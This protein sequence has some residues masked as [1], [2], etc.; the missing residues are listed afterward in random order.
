MPLR[1][2]QHQHFNIEHQHNTKTKKPPTSSQH[3]SFTIISPTVPRPRRRGPRRGARALRP[4]SPTLVLLRSINITVLLTRMAS[5]RACAELARGNGQ[6]DNQ[7]VVNCERIS[8]QLC[9]TT[10]MVKWQLPYSWL[11]QATLQCNSP[12][13]SLVALSLRPLPPRKPWSTQLEP[14]R[15]HRPALFR[16]GSH[17][18]CCGDIGTRPGPIGT[19]GCKPRAGRRHGYDEHCS[20]WYNILCRK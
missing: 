13:N 3:P 18:C 1:S 19:V 20:Y 6:V 7:V 14:S 12:Q 16:G 2:K 8:L 5:A 10:C 17:F 11:A 4:S 15:P 9:W